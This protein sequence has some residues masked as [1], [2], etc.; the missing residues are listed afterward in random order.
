MTTDH[1]DVI[2]VGAGSGGGI[3]APRLTDDPATD[4][5]DVGPEL[6]VGMRSSISRASLANALVRE[7][8]QTR[9]AQQAVYAANR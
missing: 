5:V 4:V 9:F 7:I 6:S 2:V 1:F 8:Q 3:L